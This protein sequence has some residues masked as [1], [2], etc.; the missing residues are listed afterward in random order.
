MGCKKSQCP[1]LN[2]RRGPAK[3]VGLVSVGREVSDSAEG[4]RVPVTILRDTGA[5]QTL[6]W[7]LYRIY[8]RSELVSGYVD[9]AEVQDAL[10]MATCVSEARDVPT[11]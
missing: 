3:A 4:L 1:K 9:V 8:L 6:L 11:G 7:P 10:K 5:K 2:D